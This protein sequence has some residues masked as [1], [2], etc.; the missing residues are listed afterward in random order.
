MAA[1]AAALLLEQ[2][3]EYLEDVLGMDEPLREAINSQGISSTNDFIPLTEKDV[4]TLCSNMRKPG[5]MIENPA[6]VAG[7]RGEPNLPAFVPNPGVQVGFGHEKR[8]KMLRYY[9]HHLRRTQRNFNINIATIESLT[10]IYALKEAEDKKVDIDLPDKLVAVDKVRI[11][12]ENIDNYLTRK[13]GSSGIPLLYTVRDVVDVPVN[14]NVIRAEVTIYGDMIERGPH[15]GIYFQEDNRNVWEVIRHVTHGGPGWS[16]VNSYQRDRDGREAYMAIKRHYLGES[17][18]ARLRA[19]AD[20]VMEKAFYDGKSRAFTFERFCETLKTAFTDVESTDELVSEARKVRILLNGIKDNRL[21]QA[22]SQI[23][24]TPTLKATFDSAVNFIAQFLDEKKSMGIDKEST[25]QRNISS[26]DSKP[27]GGR[28]N[29][30]YGRGGRSGGRF[31][32]RGVRG[33]R[34]RGRGY[35]GG[36]GGRGNYISNSN[37]VSEQYYKEEDWAKLSKEQQQ[38]VRDLRDER[39]KRRGVQSILSNKRARFS[40]TETDTTTSS[41]TKSPNPKQSEVGAVMSQRA[42]REF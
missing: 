28:H 33:G 27:G 18:T 3:N 32:G 19:K 8:L 29:N 14:N 40:D 35:S 11:A 10:M 23:L 25:Q 9:V 36:Y 42:P 26:Y 4:E 12:L 6:I 7:R 30:S 17:F 22:K 16:W 38:K 13:L 1:A 37:Y 24:A 15:V 21:Q 34:G 31:S 5:G 41:I 20:E 2:L 39:D